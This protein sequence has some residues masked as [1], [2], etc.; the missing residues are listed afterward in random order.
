MALAIGEVSKLFGI[1]TRLLR[2]WEAMGV[3]VP[4]ARDEHGWRIYDDRDIE[5]IGYALMY[6]ETGMSLDLIKRTLD[7]PYTA[8]EHLLHQKELLAKAQ[9]ELSKKM[10]SVDTL[11]EAEM[12]QHSL[13]PEERADIMGNTWM[14]EWELEAEKT[15]GHTQA[16]SETQQ[17]M[18]RM[19]KSDWLRYKSCLDDIEAKLANAKQREVDPSSDE[20]ATLI[21]SY[22]NLLS[23]T[24]F[25][26]S[27]AQHALI[28][29][30]YTGD[31]R[32]QA[33][34]D[35]LTPGLAVWVRQA[36][37]NRAVREGLNLATLTWES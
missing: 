1:S 13:T 29:R 34:F 11:L 22:R 23:S 7:Q 36:I 32:F 27:I 4:S 16:W 35:T 37:E 15:W 30:S 6:R 19:D 10:I 20:A 21:D 2:H 33:H 31:P 8:I 5:R 24:H 12:S 3:V 14:A 28:A 17:N 18:Q 9:E 25:C 26:M